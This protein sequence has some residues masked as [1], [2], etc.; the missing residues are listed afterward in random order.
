MVAPDKRLNVDTMTEAQSVTVT[1][2]N[3]ATGSGDAPNT[4][5]GSGGTAVARAAAAV[6]G[7]MGIEFVGTAN[8]R[9]MEYVMPGSTTQASFQMAMNIPSGQAAPTVS[10]EIAIFMN[11]T[12]TYGVK[13]TWLNTGPLVLQNGAGTTIK[14]FNSGSQLPEGQYWIWIAV[15]HGTTITNGTIHASIR[16]AATDEIVDSYTSTSANAS[17]GGTF[18][19]I[20]AIRFGKTSSSGNLTMHLDEIAYAAG[21]VAEI[22]RVALPGTAWSWKRFVR[23]G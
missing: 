14:T 8:S 3:A 7:A 15:D 12:D 21:T 5:T 2:I 18:S 17:F 22:D 10:I 19:S 1:N 9:W 6:R 20:D 4:I 13:L 23:I 11:S 16:N